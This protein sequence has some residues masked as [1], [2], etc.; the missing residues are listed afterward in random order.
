MAFPSKILVPLDF[1]P[2]SEAALGRA[3]E[4]ARV[5]NAALHLL[6]VFPTETSE[7]PSRR[8]A[9][10]IET[11]EQLGALTERTQRIMGAPVS[12]ELAEGASESLIVQR[13]TEGNYDLIAMGTHSR[14]G[15]LR[16]LAGSVAEGVI[17]GAPCPVLVVHEPA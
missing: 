12:S 17:R 3:I 7:N 14:L 4:L 11:R 1:D 16:S 5:T 2:S 10:P 15:R 8:I 9:I 6:H 13:A